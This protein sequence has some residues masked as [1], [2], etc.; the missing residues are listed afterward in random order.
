MDDSGLVGEEGR[1]RDEANW[2]DLRCDLITE[3]ASF[4]CE[5]YAKREE[6][7]RMPFFFFLLD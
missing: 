3:S 2:T 6:E 4:A 1:D 5:F 7:L